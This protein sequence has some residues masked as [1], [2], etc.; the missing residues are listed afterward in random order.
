[1]EGAAYAKVWLLDAPNALD[2]PFDYRIPERL[3][4]LICRGSLVYVPFSNT[5]KRRMGLVGE[6][7]D[8]TES[9]RTKDILDVNLRVTL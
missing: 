3:L 2:R 6:V 4:G 5:N 8:S 9:E 1:M 7:S